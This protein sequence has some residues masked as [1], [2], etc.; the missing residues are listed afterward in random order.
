MGAEVGPTLIERLSKA[1][2][3][4]YPEHPLNLAVSLRGKGVSMME[5]VCLHLECIEQ[6][7]LNLNRL[8]HIM[9][10]SRRIGITSPDIDF[11]YRKS[12][13]LKKPSERTLRLT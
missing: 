10:V 5:I 3:K 2:R 6:R 11:I 1:A 9:G 13:T 12:R 7:G 8:N 4:A